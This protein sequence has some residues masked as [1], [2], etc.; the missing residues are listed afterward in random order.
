MPAAL[1][2]TTLGLALRATALAQ[3]VL[4]PGL[5]PAPPVPA[6]PPLQSATLSAGANIEVPPT[7]WRYGPLALRPHLET[8]VLTARDLRDRDGH[9]NT[10]TVRELS[11]GLRVDLGDR[12]LADASVSWTDYT[13]SAFRDTFGQSARLAGYVSLEDW[14]VHLADTYTAD[15]TSRTETGRQTRQQ[16]NAATLG[17]VRAFG[18]RWSAETSL[19]RETRVVVDAPDAREWRVLQGFNVNLIPAVTAAARATAGRVNLDPGADLAY[20]RPGAAVTWR[21]GPKLTITAEAGAERRWRVS[22]LH[23]PRTHPVGG[24]SATFRPFSPTELTVRADESL[25][26]SYAEN[27]L[28][29]QRQWS[30]G[31]R[32]RLLVRLVAQL[33]HG[34]Q[35]TQ[36]LDTGSGGAILRRDVTRNWQFTLSTRVLRRGTLAVLWRAGRN[37]SSGTFG[38]HAR[39]TG[40]AFSFAY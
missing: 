22:G 10:T 12:W 11:P 21:P 31:L 39:Q 35:R 5:T 20:V 29:R 24:V 32:Q 4:A 18:E 36:F 30:A 6:P 26:T 37:T 3:A 7:P 25:A 16:L 14:H 17:M 1:R 28:D 15:D 8:R 27:Q 33:E 9:L 40:V 34:Q 19:T 38:Y 13:T 2:T 23:A